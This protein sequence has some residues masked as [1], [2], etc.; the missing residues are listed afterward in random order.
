MSSTQPAIGRALRLITA[1]ILICCVVFVAIGFVKTSVSI[2]TTSRTDRSVYVAFD[3]LTN[4]T[5]VEYWMEG[6]VSLASTLSRDVPVGNQS[7]LTMVTGGDTLKL[8]QEITTW[9]VG[10]RFGLHFDSEMTGGDIIV[11]LTALESGTELFVRSTFEGATWWWR[12]LFPLFASGLKATQQA[13]YD[14]LAALMDT[15]ETPLAGQW[16]GVDAAGNEQLFHFKSPEAMDWRAAS[17]GEWFELTNLR[18]EKGWSADTMTLDLSGF[19]SPPL[20][21]QTLYGIISFV[22]DDSLRLDLEAGPPGREDLRPDE[23]S[24]STIGLH[25]VR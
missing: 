12:S 11:Q 16:A 20:A 10:E 9:E 17:D 24:A 14:R 1:L 7:T 25:R 18:Y 15:L 23:F 21:G 6:F 3:A 8:R 4:A 22:S 13:D 19:S 5:L 2:E